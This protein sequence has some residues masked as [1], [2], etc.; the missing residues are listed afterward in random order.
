MTNST[1]ERIQR[2]Y[3]GKTVVRIKDGRGGGGEGG[4]GRALTS[5]V[6]RVIEFNRWQIKHK[7]SS[8]ASK[9]CIIEYHDCIEEI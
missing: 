5:M 1:H 3:L 7:I 2:S 4:R 6:L 8:I 9:D